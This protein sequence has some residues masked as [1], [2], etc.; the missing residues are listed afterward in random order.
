MSHWSPFGLCGDQAWHEYTELQRRQRQTRSWT[1]QVTAADV[2]SQSRRYGFFPCLS[3]LSSPC[4]WILC[5]SWL[6][7]SDLLPQDGDVK[8]GNLGQ[9]QQDQLHTKHW[10]NSWAPPAAK[11][12]RIWQLSTLPKPD[13][14]SDPSISLNLHQRHGWRETSLY[15]W[16][17]P[18]IQCLAKQTSLSWPKV[19]AA[20]PPKDYQWSL[21]SPG[22]PRALKWEKKESGFL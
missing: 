21:Y 6:H 18:T 19:C 3:L 5:W 14:P 7:V 22:L 13:C 12:G 11:Q 15:G 1:R 10:A 2:R 9:G 4:V 17:P 16:P 8:A 20:F